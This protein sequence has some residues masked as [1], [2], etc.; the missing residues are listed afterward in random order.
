MSDGHVPQIDGYQPLQAPTALVSPSGVSSGTPRRSVL[1]SE[2]PSERRAAERK[3]RNATAPVAV[4]FVQRQVSASTY[5]W[6]EERADPEITHRARLERARIAI[7]KFPDIIHY[8][9]AKLVDHF[10]GYFRPP[11]FVTIQLGQAPGLRLGIELHKIRRAFLDA[12]TPEE[13]LLALIDGETALW[14]HRP[15]DDTTSHAMARDDRLNSVS[16]I[17]EMLGLPE[18][19]P[20]GSLDTTFFNPAEGGA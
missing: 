10:S 15:Y 13:K 17:S 20:N 9:L 2:S 4:G 12:E 8:K 19:G 1:S 5:D 14:M 6:V 7:E 11:T 3:R 18:P 16:R